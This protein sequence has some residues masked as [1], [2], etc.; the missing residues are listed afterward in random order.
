MGIT[1]PRDISE[2]MPARVAFVGNNNSLCNLHNTCL[3]LSFTAC[4]TLTAS[5]ECMRVSLHFTPTRSLDFSEIE[6]GEKL[7]RACHCKL[8]CGKV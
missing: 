3:F 4:R 5:E 8:K 6:T 7:R 2:K 1:N